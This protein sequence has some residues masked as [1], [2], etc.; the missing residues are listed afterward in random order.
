MKSLKLALAGVLLCA[1][2]GAA[3][4]QQLNFQED[5]FSWNSTV[6]ISSVDD[7]HASGGSATKLL[8]NSIGTLEASSSDLTRVRVRASG[9]QYQGTWPKMRIWLNGTVIATQSVSSTAWTDYSFPVASPAGLNRVQVEFTNQACGWWFNDY[10][11]NRALLLDQVTLV[12]YGAPEPLDYVAMGDSYSS[13]WGAGSYDA[14]D[15]GRSAYAAQ[16]LLAAEQGMSLTNAA[17]GGA[18]TR[19]ILNTSLGGEP[20]QIE[21]VSGTTDLVTFTIGGNDTGLIWML[22]QC[23]RTRSILCLGGIAGQ[24]VQDQFN[25]KLNA[26]GPKLTNVLNAIIQRA[27]NARIRAA[28][29]PYIIP[30]E[31]DPVGCSWLENWE[32]V[33]FNQMLVRVNDKI[34][35]TAAAVAAA[36]GA[37]IAYVDPMAGTSPFMARDN[38]VVGSACSDSP[39]RY[40]LNR[41][42]HPAA[43]EGWHPNALG[44][45][46]YKHLY[47]ESLQ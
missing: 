11:C 5:A 2:G 4:G 8:R 28:G 40:M 39:S 16:V 43:N 17:C 26:L 41:Y 42:E 20:P 22:D 47:E 44:Q 15:C 46:H 1:G 35:D 13:G 3:A 6:G 9:V 29:Y 24:S 18:D 34:R 23:V 33:S 21:R 10:I 32:R 36:T 12:E 30:P 45:R 31:G 38:G 37:D 14:S 27:P 25:T 7:P 19:H